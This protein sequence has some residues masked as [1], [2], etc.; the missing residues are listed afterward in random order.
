M[1]MGE[2]LNLEQNVL[3]ACGWEHVRM[4]I[5]RRVIATSCIERYIMH[6][7]WYMYG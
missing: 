2:L 1:T 7:Y 5:P 6:T 4:C 3:D